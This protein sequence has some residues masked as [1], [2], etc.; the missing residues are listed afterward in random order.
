VRRFFA[1]LFIVIS[2]ELLIA[3]PLLL[4]TP[5]GK[6]L[7]AIIVP[8]PT[9]TPAPIL[10]PDGSQPEMKAEAAYL[11]DADT[12]RTLLSVQGDQQLPMASTTK[13]MT[14]ILAIEKGDL[15]K[16]ITIKQNAIDEAKKNN[17]STAQLVAGDQIRLRDLLYGLM[18]PSGDD[19]AISI[20]EAVGG[21]SENFVKMMNDYATND[22][23]LKHTHFIN[24]HGLTLYDAQGKADPNHYSSAADL[25]TI[26]KH[27]LSNGFF[28]QI[29]QL[30]EYRLGATGARHAYVWKTTNTLLGG[31]AG[32]TG[33]KTGFTE[34]A[35][36]CLI[37]SA[38][39]NG[40]HLIGVVMKEKDENQRFVDARAMLDWGFSLPLRPP[41]PATP[42]P[43]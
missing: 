40:H 30:Q 41:P 39:R 7:V 31:Y 1:A 34:E 24:P 32:L 37:F 21:S 28:A 15:E 23:K 6:N 5:G 2:L 19:A 20:A 42:T 11:L 14:A 10:T 35:G 26:T 36:Y 38:T 13:I 12:G 4:F 22:L 43:S 17:G 25:A 3:V 29:V 18:L 16:V 8:S 33:V 27:A 9:P